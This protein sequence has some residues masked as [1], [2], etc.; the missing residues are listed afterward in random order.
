MRDREI[1]RQGVRARVLFMM[2]DKREQDTNEPLGSMVWRLGG[3]VTRTVRDS[4]Q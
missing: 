2:D 4:I 3:S 1:E